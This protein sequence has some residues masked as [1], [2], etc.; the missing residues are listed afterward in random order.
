MLVKI[1]A[2][3]GT[4]IPILECDRTLTVIAEAGAVVTVSRV[5]SVDTSTHSAGAHNQFTVAAETRTTM[6]VDWPF[7][8]VSVVGGDCRVASV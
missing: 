6:T 4:V 1:V 2:G 5:D 8:R 3:K 7:Y